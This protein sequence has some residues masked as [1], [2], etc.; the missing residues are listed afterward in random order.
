MSTNCNRANPV[1][2]RSFIKS[3]RV[4]N[5]DVP[6]LK[7]NDQINFIMKAILKATYVHT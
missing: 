2:L 6:A 7:L 5:C 4:D 3:K 1:R